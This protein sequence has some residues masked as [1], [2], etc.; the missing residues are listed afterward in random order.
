MSRRRFR[1]LDCQIDTGKAH[2]HYFINTVTWLSVVQ[3]T[4]GMLCIGCIETRLGRQLIAADF[5][6]VSVNSPSYEP[7]SLRLLNRMGYLQ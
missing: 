6:K 3:T 7:K 2:E 1:C 5:P 4:K